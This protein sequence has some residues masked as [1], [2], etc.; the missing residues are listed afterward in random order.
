ML[1]EKGVIGDVQVT[2][3]TLIHIKIMIYAQKAEQSSEQPSVDPDSIHCIVVPH[4]QALLLVQ[5][6]LTAHPVLQNIPI[7]VPA[8][9]LE[10]CSDVSD[11]PHYLC[12]LP[13]HPG[14]VAPLLGLIEV[15]AVETTH[16]TMDDAACLLCSSYLLSVHT[17]VYYIHCSCGHD[18][19]PGVPGAVIVRSVVPFHPSNPTGPHISYVRLGPVD[20]ISG[21]SVRAI[22]VPH[23]AG[24]AFPRIMGFCQARVLLCGPTPSLPTGLLSS[25]ATVKATMSFPELAPTVIPAK[26]HPDCG[27]DIA[28][29]M[30][31]ET[32]VAVI[33]TPA[34][35]DVIA[36][37]LTRVREEAMEPTGP[38]LTEDAVLAAG[39]TR[40]GAVSRHGVDMIKFTNTAEEA[41]IMTSKRTLVQGASVDRV[42]ELIGQLSR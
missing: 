14:Q 27:Q 15:T 29:L 28:A 3:V 41:V 23:D 30:Y 8:R 40:R 26:V 18:D 17:T 4:H 35:A 12:L 31:R 24:D 32:G 1:V 38:P 5:A 7:F 19:I 37:E 22:V 21:G 11:V 39:F 9:L 33:P 36:P 6:L 25:T 2:T 20:S 13:L 34:L 10:V 42:L 16:G